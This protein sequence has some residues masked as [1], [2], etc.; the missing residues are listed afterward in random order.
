MT[1]EISATYGRFLGRAIIRIYVIAKKDDGEQLHDRAPNFSFHF[2]REYFT[3]ARESGSRI[4]RRGS[5]GA[6]SAKKV[7][8]PL[9]MTVMMSAIMHTTVT[10]RRQFASAAAARQGQDRQH[11]AAAVQPMTDFPGRAVETA[12]QAVKENDQHEQPLRQLLG[13]FS[14]FSSVSCFC[15][16][17]CSVWS[18]SLDGSAEG[19]FPPPKEFFYAIR[20]PLIT[21]IKC[22][23]SFSAA[24][25]LQGC[26]VHEDLKILDHRAHLRVDGERETDISLSVKRDLVL[27]DQVVDAVVDVEGSA[28]LRPHGSRAR[29]SY[30]PG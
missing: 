13:P 26:A 19:R 4:N 28:G 25:L 17:F 20:W 30:P 11:A 8:F 23:P 5:R 12:D 7:I 22:S 3:A 10:M 1:A 2:F 24:R 29:P 16:P 18:V 9:V 15:S 21:S 14:N 27:F 6:Q